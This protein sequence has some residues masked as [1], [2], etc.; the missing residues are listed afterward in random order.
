MCQALM[1]KTVPFLNNK[2]RNQI[3]TGRIF[4]E[5]R[6]NYGLIANFGFWNVIPTNIPVYG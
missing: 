1:Q 4:Q 6:T 5:K 3:A 2:L